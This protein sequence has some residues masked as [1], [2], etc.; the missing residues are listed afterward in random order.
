[1][2]FSVVAIGGMAFFLSQN[3]LVN[4]K[5]GAS[6]RPT[7]LP[8]PICKKVIVGGIM[9]FVCS[10]PK[11][12]PTSVPKPVTSGKPVPTSVPFRY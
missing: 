3:T 2:A 7:P 11:P 4:Y 6:A 1:L 5:S 9:K 10:T 12:S 8:T